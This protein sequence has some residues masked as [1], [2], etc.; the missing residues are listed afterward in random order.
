M[1]VGAVLSFAV[2]FSTHAS[3]R[4]LLH[5]FSSSCLGSTYVV[6]FEKPPSFLFFPCLASSSL[7]ALTTLHAAVTPFLLLRVLVPKA[8]LAQ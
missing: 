2:I 8:Q 1:G 7:Q 4:M 6:T 5:S 3:P